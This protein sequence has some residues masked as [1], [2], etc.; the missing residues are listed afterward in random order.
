MPAPQR[1]T[2]DRLTATVVDLVERDGADRLTMQ[3]VAAALDVRAPSLYK[4]VRDRDALVALARDD[5]IDAIAERLAQA[6]GDSPDERIRTMAHATRAFAADRPV[7]FSL[8]FHSA[9]L[10]P[11]PRERLSAAVAPL[12][13]ACA[14]LAGEP[15]ALV[16]ARTVTAW[17][18]GFVAMERA[19]AFRLGG[20][21]ERAFDDGLSIV[22]RGITAPA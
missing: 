10:P 17:L 8:V 9:S 2:P 20:D 14:H 5:A 1:I 22:L 4:H 16:G 18:T 12:V 19:A 13:E 11:A 3:A 21:V 7:A 6:R 15:R